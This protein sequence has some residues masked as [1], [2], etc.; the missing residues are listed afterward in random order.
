MGARGA[1]LGI[2]GA[3][4]RSAGATGRHRAEIGWGTAG[5]AARLPA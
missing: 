2:S 5:R 4:R 1:G 3:R